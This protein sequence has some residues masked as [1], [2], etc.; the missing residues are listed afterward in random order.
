MEGVDAKWFRVITRVNRNKIDE[1]AD[2]GGR[3]DRG[4]QGGMRKEKTPVRDWRVK[5]GKGKGCKKTKEEGR[6]RLKRK[7]GRSLR[8]REGRER[9]KCGGSNRHK[10]KKECSGKEGKSKVA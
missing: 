9:A 7:E 4:G 5:W 2:T 10:E 8:G 3:E 6:E 1:A